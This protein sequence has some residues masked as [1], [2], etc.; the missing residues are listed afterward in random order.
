MINLYKLITNILYPVLILL[1]YLRKIFKKEDQIRFKEK[2]FF[3]NF[4]VKRN[5]NCKLFWFHAAS[6]GE[7]KSILPLINELNSRY[8][9]VEYLITTV[10]LS[11]GDLAK[12]EIK[13]F[14]NVQHR[15]FPID[16]NFLAN[17]F[18]IN[19]KPDR[20][21][22]VDS[23]IWPNFIIAI[24]KA[25]IPI[26][27]INARITPKSFKR[28]L[29][30]SK[31]A[32]SLFNTFNLCLTS[33]NDTKKFLT[34]LK[35][36]NIFYISN[37]KLLNTIENN[38]NTELIE[39]FLLNKRFWLAASTHSGEEKF[40]LETHIKIKKKY[41][42][43]LT[44]IAPRHINRSNEINKLCNS[45][46]L[47]SKILENGDTFIGQ[48]EII[49]LNSFGVLSYYFKH[50]KCVFMGKSLIKKFDKSGGQNPIEAAKFGCKIYHGAFVYNFEEIYK[51]FQ[52]YKI[53]EK[54]DSSDELADKVALDLTSKEKDT[55]RF[56]TVMNDL[57]DKTLK[58]TM[59]KIDK[60]LLN[61]NL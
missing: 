54:I 30:F 17:K 19:W 21:F 3:S 37:L 35:A 56:S 22:F 9:K 18:L 4:N 55:K 51:I 38:K 12:K 1:I 50:A 11:S 49:I 24:K 36:K 41:P 13:K 32:E 29:M 2:I 7:I 31:F 6:V 46:N 60:F 39:D 33:N 42:E 40:C 27:L 28:W 45:L 34:K 26:A 20:I 10:T 52:S 5:H 57:S 15:Y 43:I 25:K 59:K 16:V 23:E 58:G 53:S 61:E 8:K 44:V 47:K 14:K 48:N